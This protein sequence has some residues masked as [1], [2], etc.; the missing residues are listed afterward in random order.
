MSVRPRTATA[1]LAR[2]AGLVL[3][4]S[5]P[6]AFS[7]DW[8]GMA[9]LAF[10][11]QAQLDTRLHSLLDA[12][13]GRALPGVSLRVIG[14]EIDFRGAA[15]V[16][17]LATGEPLTTD[18]AMYVASLGKTFTATIALQ[19]C[20]EGR[21]ELGSPITTWLPRNIAARVPSSNKITLRD[22]LGHR[23]GLADY[24]NDDEAWRRDFFKD[25]H[26]PWSNRDIV[27]YLPDQPL[28]F[29]P[30][31]D[32]RYSNSNY[33]LAGIIV[34]RVTGQPLNALIRERIL[35][36]L[37]LQHS[38]HGHEAKATDMSAHGYVRWRGRC[39][40]TFPWFHHEGLADSGM[41]ATPED[42]AWFLRSLLATDVLLSESMRTQMTRIPASGYPPSGY[43]LG[44]FMYRNLWGGGLAYAHDGVDPGYEADMVYFPYLD[45]TIV[46]CANASLGMADRVYE[47]LLPAVVH[48]VLHA[49]RRSS[50]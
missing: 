48:T 2:L 33:I 43:G 25:P 17:N 11:R 5:T 19:L 28:L 30:G 41:H 35:E 7:H 6:G 50:E 15:G 42:I 27:P 49:V 12:A 31:T 26:R 13:V 10:S 37:G 14:P 40:D 3:L 32:F 34:E 9:P 18:H 1:L 4:A 24:L 45:L 22:L 29:E 36:P 44:L 8:H 39:I 21:L 20:E 38:F 46:L 47:R 16:A 23:S